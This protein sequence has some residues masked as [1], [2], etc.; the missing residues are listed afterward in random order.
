VRVP[1]LIA[2]CA[3]A[4]LVAAPARAQTPASTPTGF[5]LA[6]SM[7]AGGQL[8][9]PQGQPA[10]LFEL[11]LLGGWEHAP[12][13]LQAELAV[14]FGLGADPSF[15]L[16][17]GL[18]Y[19]LERLPISV[20]A[21]LDFSNA[22]SDSSGLH[23]RWLLF[24]AAWDLRF[25]SLFALSAGLESGIPLSGSAGVPFMVRLGGTFRP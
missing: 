4:T 12:T 15:A 25:T 6:A 18:R 2:A 1:K 3:L 16:R 21:A 17:P 5:V 13:R 14:A 19:G 20:R 7:A 23:A 9:L 10:G 24:G 22:G 8:G 11:E